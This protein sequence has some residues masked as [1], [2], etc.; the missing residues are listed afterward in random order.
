MLGRLGTMF[1]LVCSAQHKVRVI[2]PRVF[3]IQCL[4]LLEESPTSAWL[5]CQGYRDRHEMWV[6]LQAALKFQILL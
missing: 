3:T 2:R 1:V 5:R 4:C 6:W